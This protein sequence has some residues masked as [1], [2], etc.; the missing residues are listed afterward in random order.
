MSRILVIGIGNPLRGDDGLG[1]HAAEKLTERL[2]ESIFEVVACHQLMP[3]LA[4]R[5]AQ[6]KMVIFLD[7]CMGTK[8]GALKLTRIA[9]TGKGQPSSFSHELQPAELLAI[10][11]ALYGARPRGVVLSMTGE[12]FGYSTEL[13]APVQRALPRLL[14]RAEQVARGAVPLLAE[15]AVRNHYRH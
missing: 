8:A 2:R 12:S 9:S 4:E 1:R 6:A 13:S 14:R 7:A 15:S 5:V 11:E 3:E 10:A